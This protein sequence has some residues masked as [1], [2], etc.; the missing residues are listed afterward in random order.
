MLHILGRAVAE[1]KGLYLYLGTILYMLSNFKM[2]KKPVEDRITEV[3]EI[4]KKLE[5]IGLGPGVEAIDDFRT[6]ANQYV[7]SGV[8]VSGAI[9]IRGTNRV[10]CYNLSSSKKETCAVVLKHVPN[11]SS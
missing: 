11:Q 6:I 8:H 5:S 3:M 10:L 7:R 1:N 2:G 4:Y 9:P